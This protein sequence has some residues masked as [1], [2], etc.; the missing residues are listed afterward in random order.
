MRT[1]RAAAPAAMA[2]ITLVYVLVNVAYYAVVDRETI[3]H[4]GRIAAA[5]F[6]GRLWG[7]WTERVRVRLAGCGLLR[8]ADGRFGRW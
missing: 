3:L 4:S 1:L 7:Q 2:G 8:R 5:L 6:F